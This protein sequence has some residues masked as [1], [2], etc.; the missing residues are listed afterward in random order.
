[1]D[2]GRCNSTAWTYD[3]LTVFPTYFRY[4]DTIER[5]DRSAHSATTWFNL[6]QA[7]INAGR[8]MQYRISGHSIVCDGWRD[9][10]GLNQ[11]H[12]NYGWGDA[13]TTWYTIDNLYCNWSGCD[14]MVEYVIRNIIPVR[15]LS[16]ALSGTLGP[17][18]YTVIGNISISAGNTL[19]IQPDVVLNFVGPYSFSISGSLLAQGTVNDSI[20]FTS[21]QSGANRWHGLRFTGAGSSGSVLAYCRIENGYA[22]G[23]DEDGYGGGV[24]CNQSSPSF[25]HCRII[26]N[27][28]VYGG[29]GVQCYWNSS[30]SFSLCEISGDTAGYG[31][32]V[33]CESYSLPFFDECR[34]SD[35]SA[36]NGGG[37]ACRDFSSP[38]FMTCTVSG[39]SAPDGGG[40]VVCYYSSSPSFT[41]CAIDG[42]SATSGG[43]GLLCY[44]SSPSFTSCTL[45]G[46]STSMNGGGAYMAV[47]SPIFINTIVAFSS[48]SGLYFYAA[49][50]SNVHHCD[51]FGNSGG[52]IAFL[53]GDPSNGPEDIG[54]L[55]GL[56]ANG[57]SCDTYVNIFLDP[58]FA[59]APARDL[60]LTDYSPCIGAGTFVDELEEDFE[61]D[62][63]PNPWW[64]SP[65]IGMDEHW[66][67][68]PV[69]HLVI[70]IVGGNAV[71][72]WPF[73]SY[74]VN[75]YGTTSL[76]TAGTL[77][78]T[79]DETTTWTDVNTS[80]RP[81]RYFYYVT[82]QLNEGRAR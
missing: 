32:G 35:N 57:D 68:G 8:P 33:D 54:Q 48:G 10:G 51:I 56:N 61:H 16:G 20:V 78:E 6:I 2:Y 81:S 23:E 21:N 59:N 73:F 66:L 13:F 5:E 80:S 53:D 74:T 24:Y 14:P 60:H 42:N 40:G 36:S 34:I 9:T 43:G 72:N 37:V 41:N 77:L 58:L 62:P 64:S 44:E 22:A 17:G 47:S 52:E 38:A 67:A 75:I 69:R 11:Y 31:G 3:A 28:A 7:E 4:S 71:L 45:Y 12:M 39:N 55:S 30:P 82:A 50:G 70:R 18:T 26:G 79:V 76:F 25:S 65:D 46:N 63:R 29:G 19:T 1:M 49:A 15:E 27:T